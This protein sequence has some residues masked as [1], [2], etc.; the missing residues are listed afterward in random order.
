MREAIGALIV[1]QQMILF[2]K[3]AVDRDFYPNVWDVF[4]GHMEPGESYEETLERELYEELGIRPTVWD[5]LATFREPDPDQYGEGQ[6]HF[7]IVTAWTG[8]LTN[9]HPEEHDEI[10]WFSFAE[11]IQLELPHPVYYELLARLVS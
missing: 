5:Y 2:G 10:Q 4:G 8:T 6:Y 9:R 11:A 3:R 7:C 1:K